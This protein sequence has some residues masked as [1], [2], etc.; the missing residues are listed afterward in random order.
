MDT[1]CSKPEES[2]TSAPERE[3]KRLHGTEASLLNHDIPLL[4]MK[5][6]LDF[7]QLCVVD[8]Y[9]VVGEVL[10]DW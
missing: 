4:L 7:L 5:P 1:A 9:D 3:N 10:E 8:L 2:C 6:C